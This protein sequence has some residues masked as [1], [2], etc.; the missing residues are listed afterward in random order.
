[1]N[2]EN[3]LQALNVAAILF[4]HNVPINEAKEIA[5]FIEELITENERLK[6]LLQDYELKEESKDED[7]QN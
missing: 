4:K 1:M 5:S 6:K 2:K 7:L 3:S